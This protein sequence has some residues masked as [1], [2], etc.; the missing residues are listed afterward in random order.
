MK[1]SEAKKKFKNTWVLAEVIREN[2]INEP[3]EVKPI[4]VSKDRNRIYEK[5]TKLPRGKTVTTFYTGKITGSFLFK[6]KL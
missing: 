6:C 5:M 1:I 4:M 3:V 2:K